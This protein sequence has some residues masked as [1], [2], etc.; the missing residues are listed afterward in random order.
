MV[1]VRIDVLQEGENQTPFQI[2]VKCNRM[3]INVLVYLYHRAN[4]QHSTQHIFEFAISGD[5]EIEF[6]KTNS[7]FQPNHDEPTS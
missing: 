5:N 1:V 3:A 4:N 2:Q 6:N 7:K